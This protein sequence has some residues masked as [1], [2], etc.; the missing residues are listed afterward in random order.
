MTG[1]TQLFKKRPIPLFFRITSLLFLLVLMLALYWGTIEVLHLTDNI[2]MFFIWTLWWPFLYLTLLFIAR[3]WCG[4]LCPLSLANEL[5]NKVRKGK[6]PNIIKWG[7]V[8]YIIFFIV[9]FAEQA[10]GLFLSANITILFFT[11][12][13]G[14]AFIFGLLFSRWGFC[15]LACP[16]G[17]LLGVFSRLSFIG[18]RTQEEKCKICKTR[19][20]M[21]GGKTAPCPMLNNI[22]NIKSNKNC[23]LCTKCIKNCPYDSPKI[24][25]VMPGKEIVDEVTF[26]MPESLFIIALIGMTFTLNT[27]GTE[28]FRSVLG[29]IGLELRGSLLRFADFAIAIGLSLLFFAVLAYLTS[30]VTGIG[31]KAGLKKSGYIYLPLA[32]FILFFTILFGF[33]GPHLKINPAAIA[34]SKYIALAVGILWSLYFSYKLVYKKVN[35][36]KLTG[37]G[38]HAA[39]I[40]FIGILWAGY[41]IPGPLNVS[42]A[43]E[44]SI[45]VMPNETIIIDAFSMGFSPSTIIANKDQV[46]SIDFVNKDIVHAFDIDEF[47]VHEILPA[48]KTVTVQFTPDKAGEFGFYCNIPGHTE[49]GMKGTLIVKEEE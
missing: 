11:I 16:I 41:L 34:F 8:A 4:F 12:F 26:T 46:V 22:A 31:S 19:E 38:L 6:I 43:V 37:A 40:L 21:T 32:F 49:A 2:A 25:F 5:G 42:A 35:K 36:N 20:C 24:K 33:L 39:A 23:L 18:L 1:F 47:G 9:V 44:D 48:G 28:I 29:F 3:A 17:T 13:F 15:R 27:R 7:F 30:K 10:S 45:T 14:T